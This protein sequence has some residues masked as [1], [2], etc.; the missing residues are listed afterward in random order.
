MANGLLNKELSLEKL[1]E[2]FAYQADAPLLFSSGLFLFLFIGFLMIYLSLRKNTL[3]RMVYVILF[4][5]YFYYK[6]SGIWFV[7]LLFTATTDFLIGKGL[8]RT[9]SVVA[10]KWLVIASLC[11]NLGMLCYFKY[12]NFLLNLFAQLGHEIGHLT[13]NAALQSLT[14]TPADIFLPV[15]ISFFTF[16][17]LSYVIDI[18]RRQIAPVNR[19][20]DYLFYVSFFPQ[21]V[22]GP[23]VRARDFLP[24]IHQEPAVS[25]EQFGEGFYLIL[26]GLFKKAVISDYI[27]L[28][29]VDRVFDAPLLYTGV[30]NLLGVYGYALQIYC[31][32]SGYSDMAIGIA[33]LLGFR[34]SMNFDSPYQSATIT[35]FWRR[36][37]ISL[38]SWLKDYL[39]ISLGGNRK[40]KMRTY[41]NLFITMLLGGLWHGASLRFLFWGAWHGVALGVHKFVMGRFGGFKRQGG[42]MTPFRRVLGMFVTFH[43]VCF[44]WIF[45]RAGTMQGAGEMISQIA[46]DFHPEVFLPF[47]AGYKGV[48]FLMV[49][50]YAFHLMPKRSEL[51]V[52]RIVT[53][54]PLLV[55]AIML[56][57]IIFIVVQ[58]KSAGVQPFIYF[59]F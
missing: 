22:A 57:I 12:T 3:A 46:T 27:S 8:S 56:V 37:H 20:T 2:L 1:P 28:N 26:C 45:F 13:G 51:Y 42:E 41:A 19:W 53:R 50:G 35:E 44:G 4:S 10:R 21:L 52:R 40:G 17:S 55:Q 9:A 48:C 5:L 54:S 47:V 11:V 59:Q 49:L 38:S 36:W 33:L 14:Y 18:Y 15:G 43:T 31:D 30:E 25:R 7:L 16:Q 29:F 24:Q 58:V 34:F 6:S 39:Y 32:F 23:I